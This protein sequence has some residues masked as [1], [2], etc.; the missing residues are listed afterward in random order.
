[1]GYIT[2]EEATGEII[3]TFRTR[4]RQKLNLIN[5]TDLARYCTQ[6]VLENG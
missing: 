5:G 3:E 4:I 2:K 6:W 1:M